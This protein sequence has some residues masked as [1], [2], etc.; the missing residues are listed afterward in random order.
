MPSGQK[1]KEIRTIQGMTQQELA[2]K[3]KINLRTIQRI[4][5]EEV[6][7]RSYTLKIIARVLMIEYSELLDLNPMRNDPEK[8]RKETAKLV[9][10]HLSAILFVPTFL[11]WFFEKEHSRDIKQ[12][13]ADI[14]NFQLSMLAVLLPCLLFAG[15]PQI[16][17]LFTLIV[18]LINSVRVI[19]GKSYYYPLSIKILKI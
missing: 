2:L 17:S 4:E 3:A 18:V 15:L 6:M 19:R 12:H 14:I 9:W 1:I 16:V 5:N 10:L 8:S 11:I 7:P 13:G